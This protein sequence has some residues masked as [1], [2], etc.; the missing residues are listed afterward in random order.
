MADEDKSSKTE[1]PTQ[2]RLDELF[3]KGNLPKA[4]EIGVVFI[5]IA[6][7]GLLAFYGP[8]IGRHLLMFSQ[9]IWGNLSD[10]PVTQTSMGYYMP[11]FCMEGLGMVIPLMLVCFV[12]AVAGGGLQTGFRIPKEAL[13]LKLDKLNFING[14]GRLF[15]PKK[16]VTFVFEFAK[17]CVVGWVVF[18]VILDIQ[19][20][21]IFYTIVPVAHVVQFIYETFL[22]I[23]AKLIISLGIIAA[24]H[25]AYQKWQ[26]NEDNKMTKQEVKDEFKNSEGNPEVKG[27]R[28]RMARMLATKETFAKVPLADVV[29]TNPT[30]FAVA[31]KYE[32]GKDSA[33]IV[34][35]KG[36]NLFAQRIKQLA[37]ENG[38]PMV[39]NRPVARALFKHA[40]P[41]K[42][43]PQALFESVASILAHVYRTHRYYFHRL[44]ARRLESSV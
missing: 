44:K 24:L 8:S 20:D 31:L 25:F 11:Q 40:Q 10:F 18:G 5:L 37:A 42:A 15:S 12:A 36:K 2:K 29:V 4:P 26:F 7:F 22:I 28:K 19:K 38:V 21:P 43:I 27:A 17:F 39:E 41:N 6:S 1:E 33:P 35:A 9:S 13:T 16:L 3:N 32:R 34:L 14:I 30:H 23:L